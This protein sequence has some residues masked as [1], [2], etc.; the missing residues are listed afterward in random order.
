MSFK[1]FKDEE[2]VGLSSDLVHLL[3]WTRDICG[4]P[5]VITSGFRTPEHNAT[6][7]GVQDSTHTDG[8]AVDIRLPI[9]L[10]QQFK[11]VWALGLAGFNRM[12]IYTKHIHVDVSDERPQ[13]VMWYGDSH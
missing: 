5:I 9:G 6:V 11:L 4:F 10:E 8:E 2:V 1:H 3:D 12:G 13:N 7:G